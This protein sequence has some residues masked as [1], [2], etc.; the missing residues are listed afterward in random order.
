[1]V[2]L[3]SIIDL[4]Y[5]NPIVNRVTLALRMLSFDKKDDYLSIGPRHVNG[6]FIANLVI[7]EIKLTLLK[8]NN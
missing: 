7:Q 1:M 8:F 3:S 6:I 4:L 2:T 5:A